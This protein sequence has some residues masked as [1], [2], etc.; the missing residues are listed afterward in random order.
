M[1]NIINI[2]SVSIYNNIK[3]TIGCKS[4]YYYLYYSNY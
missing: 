3:Y 2:E 1:K 4:S